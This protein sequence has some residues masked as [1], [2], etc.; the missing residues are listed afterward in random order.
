MDHKIIYDDGQIKWFVFGRDPNRPNSIIDTNEY[1]IVASDEV[2][3]LDPGGT[4]IFPYVLSSVSEVIGLEKITKF[5]CSHQDPDI[6]SSLPLW[7]ALC[8]EATVYMPRIWSNFMSHF[9]KESVSNFYPVPDQGLDIKLGSEDLQIIPAHFLHASGNI[10]LFCPRSRILFSG[11][12]GSALVPGDYPF[13]TE[14]FELHT[15]YMKAFHQRWMPSN[16]AK[17]S[18]IRRVRAL[19]PS[20]ICPQHGSI[21]NGEKMVGQFLDWLDNTEVGILKND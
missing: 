6:F 15:T 19:N 4:E 7:M 3:I 21:F 16:R 9:G 13:F 12:L 20:M 2:M 18:W 11:D 5:L 14:D 10:N 8:P 17:S 1:A